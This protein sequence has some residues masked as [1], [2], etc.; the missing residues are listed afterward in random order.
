MRILL[1]EDDPVLRCLL[2]ELLTRWGH[3]TLVAEDGDAA[4][5][6]VLS[7]EVFDVAILD[8][9]MPGTT[10]PDVCRRIR[11]THV[12]RRPFVLMLTAKSELEDVVGGLDAGADEYLVKPYRPAELAARV[13][14]AG[15][16]MRMQD[17]LIAARKLVAYQTSH[18]LATGALN[19]Q[20]V[21]A[22]L[23][24]L[25]LERQAAPSPLSVVRVGI[26]G[27]SGE[28]RVRLDDDLVKAVFE[29]V[30]MSAPG[31]ALVGRTSDAELLVILPDADEPEALARAAA[32]SEGLHSSPVSTPLGPVTVAVDTGV[33]TARTRV[34]LDLAWLLCAIDAL[35]ASP[36]RDGAPGG[37]RF[38]L[39]S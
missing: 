20:A 22:V 28:R 27:G 2:Q 32:I 12:D 19:R 37:F 30:T 24:G 17:D 34:D 25:L 14:A 7:G 26:V 1:A 8:W 13:R 9:M 31:S 11:E 35:A 23:H 10:G 39:A 15:R 36:A 29:R 5:A 18:D 3:E 16:L 33:V 4:V 38:S 6:C 21:L